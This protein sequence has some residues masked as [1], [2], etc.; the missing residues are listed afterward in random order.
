VCNGETRLLALYAFNDG[1][2]TAVCCRLLGKTVINKK[3]VQNYL[4]HMKFGDYYCV[5]S[6]K[7][8]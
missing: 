1:F 7:G 6:D 8:W 3:Y 4:K 2:E 5:S